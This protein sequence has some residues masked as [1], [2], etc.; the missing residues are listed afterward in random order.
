ML[1]AEI[2]GQNVLKEKYKDNGFELWLKPIEDFVKTKYDIDEIKTT[3]YSVKFKLKDLVHVNVLVSP[4]WD[5][6][7]ELYGFLKGI[8]RSDHD[9]Y[10]PVSSCFGHFLILLSCDLGSLQLPP[11]GSRSSF[12]KYPLRYVRKLVHDLHGYR[13]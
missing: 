3:K 7:S 10:M 9:R 13:N 1:S 6:K 12:A 5:K 2:T 11:S 8:E 4:Y